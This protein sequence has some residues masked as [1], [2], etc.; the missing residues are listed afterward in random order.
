MEEEGGIANNGSYQKDN[1]YFS[2]S[3]DRNVARQ[4][5]HVLP[6]AFR[7]GFQSM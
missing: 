4:R 1:Y 7:I 3:L 5:G 6:V 2:A